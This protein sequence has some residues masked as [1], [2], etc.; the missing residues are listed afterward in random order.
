MRPDEYTPAVAIAE[1]RARIEAARPA[2]TTAPD[3][4]G[5]R[6]TCAIDCRN[7]CLRAEGLAGK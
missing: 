1:A 2:C 7:Y 4:T 6:C 3:M 5:A